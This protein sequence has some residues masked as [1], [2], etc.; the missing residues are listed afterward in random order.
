MQFLKQSTAVT[1][2]MGPFLDAL[3]GST[4][5][6]SLTLTPEIAKA[7]AGFAAR[8][9]TSLTFTADGFYAVGLSAADTDTLGGLIVK[10]FQA[11]AIPVWHE[12]MVLAP[13]AYDALCGT[14]AISANVTQI[15]A[16]A[17]DTIL[18]Q[19]IAESSIFAWPGSLR[20]VISWLGVLS[21]NKMTQT[22]S[23][24][25]VRNDADNATLGTSTHSDD[26][27]THTRGEF[28]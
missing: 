24:Q 12:F 13:S 27:T 11:G 25:V 23:T 7:G 26:G 19:P 22:A 5:E 9:G 14:G 10:D 16:A 3:D 28:S 18:D 2:T 6:N 21:R 17:V 1:I 8:T 20:K 4:P 15:Q